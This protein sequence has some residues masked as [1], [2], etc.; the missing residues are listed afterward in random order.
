MSAARLASL[1]QPERMLADLEHLATLTDTSRAGYTREA[2]TEFDIEG[3]QWILRRFRDAGLQSSIDGAGNVIGVLP[4]THP[5][6]GAIMT[7]SHTDT[8]DGGGRFDGNVGVVAALEIV[9]SLRESRTVLTHDLVVADFFSE[10]P[11]RFGL[12]CL[13]SRALTGHLRPTDLGRRD[14]QGR[15]LGDALPDAGV[16]PAGMLDAAI[17]TAR[18]KAFLELHIE[19][20]PYLEEHGSQIGLV[21]S[22]AGVSRFRG[23]FTGRRDHAGT[24]PMHR[25][26][27]AGCAAAGT[28]LAIEK[29]A[30]CHP[31][32]RG[33]TGAVTFSPEAVNVIT[34]TATLTG[35]F[36]SP[37]LIW[38]A[39]AAQRLS[40]VAQQHATERGVEL[41]LDWV[42]SENPSVMSSP[43]LD[44]CA[45]VTDRLGLSQ[46]RLYSGAE[47]DAAIIAKHIPTAM[48][49]VPSHD[50]RSHC[51]EEFTDSAAIIDGAN[52]LL[53]ALIDTDRAVSA[54][55]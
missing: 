30:A 21:T 23:V 35:E 49:F 9:R 16:D 24:T 8:V 13:G 43:L 31:D 27:D 38:L 7:G 51:P 50:G 26:R 32:G 54:E 39:E 22:I 36:R 34:Q 48:V 45:T 3:R 12:S 33:T 29:I 52:V 19:Q 1:A 10:E 2:L 37:D 28:V 42:P 25:R 47:H 14:D 15:C 5:A 40:T 17:D 6:A 11:N 46:S 18:I 20:G 41:Q 53:N 44:I 55:H 4:G